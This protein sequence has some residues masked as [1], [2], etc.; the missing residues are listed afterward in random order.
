MD[1]SWYSSKRAVADISSLT[2]MLVV[3]LWPALAG[4]GKTYLFLLKVT[5]QWN[6][7]FIL[8]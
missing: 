8:I 5:T 1:A 3:L 6:G 4:G 2:Q 7:I